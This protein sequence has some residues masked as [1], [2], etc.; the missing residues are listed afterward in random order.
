MAIL[1]YLC[2][3]QMQ[4]EEQGLS[5]DVLLRYFTVSEDVAGMLRTI[6]DSDLL[7][8]IQAILRWP[9]RLRVSTDR[10]HASKAR[11]YRQSDGVTCDQSRDRLLILLCD[12]LGQNRSTEL[13]FMTVE[14]L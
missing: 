13:C 7:Q 2:L 9:I 10:C 5:L 6:S 11:I 8:H 14:E 4:I 3:L 12:L 1:L